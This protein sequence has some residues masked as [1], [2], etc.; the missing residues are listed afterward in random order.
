[1]KQ[2]I[3]FIVIILSQLSSFASHSDTSLV[4]VFNID[5]EIAPPVVRRMEKAFL[6]AKLLDADLIIIHMNTYGGLLVS[7]DTIRTRILNSKIPIIVYIDNNAASAGALISIACDSIYMRAGANIGAA[8]VVNQTAQAMPDK[9]Q[10]YMR[11]TMRATAEAKGRN[12]RIAEAMVDQDIFIKGISEK[13]KVL[14]FTTSEAIKNGY[15]EAEVNSIDQIIKR[16]GFTNYKVIYLELKPIDSVI[17][18]LISP[19]IHG[20][21]IMV[22]I[23]GLYFEMQTPG[24]GFPSIASLLAA[25]LYF[26]PLYVEGIAENWEI[27][28]FVIG[29]ILMFLEVMVIPGFGIAG[30]SG[31]VFMTTGLILS[32]LNNVA[33]DFSLVTFNAL[34]EAVFIV[35]FSIFG[36]I[37]IAFIGIKHVLT[38]PNY[39]LALTTEMKSKDGFIS[40]KPETKNLIGSNAIAYTVLRPAGKIEFENS[41][42]DAIAEESF[43]NKGD[44]VIIVDYV[45]SQLVVRRL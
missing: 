13:G 14:T 16:Y 39:G 43:I 22:I 23:G 24:L 45:N 28:I 25:L 11:A 31:I 19:F 5:E 42:Y 41:I 3:L 2:V 9:Y 36:S 20:I 12:P 44:K 33:L 17:D 35:I 32:L 21:L 8:T 38:N 40:S 26:A 37:I 18:F 6:Q 15:C 34:L 10:S 7:A 29:V 1:M 30:V 4:Y 27:L